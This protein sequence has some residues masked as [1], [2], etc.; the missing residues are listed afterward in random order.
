MSILQNHFHHLMENIFDNALLYLSREKYA[1]KFEGS[2][3]TVVI[4]DILLFMDIF[5]ADIQN[6]M[7][8]RVKFLR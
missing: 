2:H 8:S 4:D 3:E 1:L 5:I 6:K 7:Q